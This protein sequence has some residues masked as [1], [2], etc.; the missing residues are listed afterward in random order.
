[1]PLDLRNKCFHSENELFAMKK[2]TAEYVK[3]K[4]KIGCLSLQMNLRKKSLKRYV[5]IVQDDLIE[6]RRSTGKSLDVYPNRI[7]HSHTEGLI[8]EPELYLPEI[9][10]NKQITTCT[11]RSHRGS[12]RIRAVTGTVR[13]NNE[14][15]AVVKRAKRRKLKSEGG[16][17]KSFISI[18]GNASENE[19]LVKENTTLSTCDDV[20]DKIEAYNE[21][22]AQRKDGT[23]GYTE[24]NIE[25]QNNHETQALHNQA[26]HDPPMEGKPL[27][28]TKRW[29]VHSRSGEKLDLLYIPQIKDCYRPMCRPNCSTC[30]TR[31]KKTPCFLVPGINISDDHFVR[32][33]E[34]KPVSESFDSETNCTKTEVKLVNKSNIDSITDE[35]EEKVLEKHQ[36]SIEKNKT[37]SEFEDFVIE[38]QEL[39][40]QMAKKRLD[41]ARLVE[42]A[43]PKNES[44]RIPRFTKTS[45]RK[46]MEKLKGTNSV[47]NL[48]MEERRRLNVTQGRVALFLAELNERRNSVIKPVNEVL[49]FPVRENNVFD[50]SHLHHSITLP[51][52]TKIDVNKRKVRFEDVR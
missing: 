48:T 28:N 36:I 8:Q 23:F 6:I 1:M 11:A 49:D 10:V 5:K 45:I 17:S 16:L 42:L 41:T 46:D 21:L 37:K 34:N 32:V 33:P 25:Q 30:L 13:S 38:C 35:E 27:E 3:L 51:S 2:N 4:E 20:F 31:K 7:H 50:F 26:N 14:L 24:C 44:T 18:N 22:K 40:K 19:M 39:H 52:F 9:E 47:R 43:K 15:A 29:Q 12:C